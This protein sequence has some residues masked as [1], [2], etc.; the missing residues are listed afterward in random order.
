MIRFFK[1]ALEVVA[2]FNIF[3]FPAALFALVGYVVYA[4]N[5]TGLG[6]SALIFLSL[7]GVCLGVYLAERVRKRVGCSTVLFRVFTSHD[8]TKSTSGE[9]RENV[10]EK[11]KEVK[12]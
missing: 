11:E 3:L 6:I 7:A 12:K 10:E 1:N 9:G 5:K 2:W 4:N 8:I